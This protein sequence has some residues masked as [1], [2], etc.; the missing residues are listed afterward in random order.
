MSEWGG[1]GAAA[2]KNAIDN[3]FSKNGRFPLKN[4][5]EKLVSITAD[6]ASVNTGV[7]SGLFTRMDIE[8]DRPWLVKIHC[9]NHRVELAVSAAFET[10]PFNAVDKFYISN[11]ALL[12]NSGAIKSAVKH[13]CA[14]LNISHYV[15]TKMTGTRFVSHRRR[16]LTRLIN[17]WPA[18][19]SAYE[20]TISKNT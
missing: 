20:T 15:L 12:K 14:A 8:N 9:V 13:S 1:T 18:L 11:Y 2:L 16:A 19:T 5:R 3:I 6:G 4:Y 10:S 7:R 17:I